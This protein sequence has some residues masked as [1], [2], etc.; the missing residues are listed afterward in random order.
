MA[1]NDYFGIC[2]DCSE[3]GVFRNIGREHYSCCDAHRVFWYVGSNLFSSWRDQTEEQWAANRDLLSG[4][5]EVEEHHDVNDE[6]AT[7]GDQQDWEF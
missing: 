7:Q 3:P 2:P 5:R 4:Y 6:P 1:K